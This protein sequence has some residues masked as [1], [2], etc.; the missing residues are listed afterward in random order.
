Y[1]PWRPALYHWTVQALAYSA[2]A[3]VQADVFIPIETL[4]LA[5]QFG[6]MGLAFSAIHRKFAT[7]VNR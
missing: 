3:S 4:Y 1:S 5:L 6:L 2:K 7:G